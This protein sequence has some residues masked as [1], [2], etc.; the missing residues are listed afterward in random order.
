MRSFAATLTDHGRTLTRDTVTVLQINLG[1]RCNQACHHCHVEAGPKRSEMMDARTADRLIEL[2]ASAPHVR[3]VDIT[4][5]APELNPQFRR[6]VTA[7]RA[8]GKD[9][10]DRCN[11]T[12]LFEPGQETTAQFLADH[13]VA[14]VA[15]LPC[16]SEKNVDAQRGRGVFGQSIK[17]LQLLNRLGYGT[18]RQLDLVYNPVGAHLPPAQAALEQDYRTR[19]RSDFGIEFSRLLT[20]TNMP[21]SRF[22]HALERDGEA[23]AYQQLLID[24]FNPQ[25]V[26]GVMC[27]SMLSVGWDGKLYDCDFNQMLE[28]KLPGP[29]HTIWDIDTLAAVDRRIAMGPHCFGCTA[30]A[31][32]SCGGALAA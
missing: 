31:G 19:L 9:V 1:K 15:S 8:L 7:A 20:I 17:A 30:G 23:Q 12:I 4:G 27:R 24:S 22:L 32:S 10:I 29:S 14:I 16:Y 28:M 5:G 26:D 18:T 13:Q 25:A 21:I 11:L 6:L 2:L 3:T